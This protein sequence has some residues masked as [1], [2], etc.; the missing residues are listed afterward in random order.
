MN[1][2]I[3]HYSIKSDFFQTARYHIISWIKQISDDY[4]IGISFQSIESYGSIYEP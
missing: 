3:S 4:G 1:I 2:S